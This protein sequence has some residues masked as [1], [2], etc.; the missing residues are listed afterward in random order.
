MAL[1]TSGPISLA[2]I[3]TEFGGSN[4]IS[5]SEY[6][7]AAAGIP[8]SGVISI[9]DFYGASANTGLITVTEG[10]NSRNT[11]G[12]FPSTIKCAGY[13]I[14]TTETTVQGSFLPPSGAI[15]SI[16][17]TTYN[18]VAVEALV[19]A[20]STYVGPRFLVNI[21]GNRAKSFFTSVT[22]QGGNTLTSAS[23]THTYNSSGNYTQ[24]YWDDNVGQT[25]VL[26]AGIEA[27]WDGTGTSTVQ[28]A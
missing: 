13:A 18:G 9:G 25:V 23:A 28:F 24:W 10:S 21:Q 26:G 6:Y 7:G 8:A 12:K 20:T 15:G 4:P 3:Q 27:Q 19:L 16:S 17:P 11:G 14:D 22:P 2:D 1:Q 5:I